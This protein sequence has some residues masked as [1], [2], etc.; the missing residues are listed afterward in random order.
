VFSSHQLELSASA[1]VFF[2]PSELRNEGHPLCFDNHAKRSSR[3]PFLLIVMQNARGCE[4]PYSSESLRTGEPHFSKRRL[5]NRFGTTFTNRLSKNHANSSLFMRLRTLAK[6]IG[7]G[8]GTV[9][10]NSEV[11]SRIRSAAPCRTNSTLPAAAMPPCR[12]QACL[13]QAG[14]PAAGRELFP[15]LPRTSLQ[16]PRPRPFA[17]TS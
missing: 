4:V 10:Q 16:L 15:T 3:I 13:P 12:R 14:P 7:D 1:L 11:S 5:F 9:R 2:T 17:G 8:M 6:N